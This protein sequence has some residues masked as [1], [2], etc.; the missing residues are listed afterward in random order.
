MRTYEYSE[1]VADATSL[2]VYYWACKLG[3]F[4]CR[5]MAANMLTQHLS[6]TKKNPILPG[7]ENWVYCAGLMNANKSVWDQ[8]A[9]H[10]VTKNRVMIKHLSCTEDNMIVNSFLNSTIFDMSSVWDYLEPEQLMKL[11]R[12]VMKK[13]ARK[14]EVVDFILGYF[15][16]LM[17][18]HM[19]INEKLGS[20][21]MNVYSRCQLNQ[22]RYISLHAYKLQVENKSILF[23]VRKD[24]T[25]CKPRM[26]S[27][28]TETQTLVLEFDKRILSAFPKLPVKYV[29]G[30]ALTVMRELQ[31]AS[32]R[33]FW[34]ILNAAENEFEKNYE[35]KLKEVMESWLTQSNTPTLYVDIEQYDNSI[36]VRLMQRIYD[37]QLTVIRHIK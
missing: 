13:H 37:A 20:I 1:T 2:L 15:D 26:Y 35:Y 10:F 5:E 4:K 29:R 11:Y 31:T 30:W 12:G 9:R 22:T 3:D 32:A 34:T 7:W 18:H 6:N 23:V 33:Q 8:A 19:N 14:K 36:I 25:V 27:Y 21:I 28:C 24:N 17:S 16:E